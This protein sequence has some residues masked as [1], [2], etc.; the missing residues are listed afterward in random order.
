M[1]RNLIH[2]NFNIRNPYRKPSFQNLFCIS[3]LFTKHK[4]WEFEVLYV[5]QTIVECDFSIR[6]KTDHAGL[7]LSFGLFGYVAHFVIYD[8]RHWDDENDDYEIYEGYY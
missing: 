3:K 2:F 7:D 4:A 1:R 8:T 6:V 5:A